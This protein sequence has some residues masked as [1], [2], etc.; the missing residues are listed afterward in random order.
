M[1]SHTGPLRKK[2]TIV[3]DGTCGK[4]CLLMTYVRGVFP[5]VYVPTVFENYISDLEVD[6][7]NVEL[8]LW[9]TAGQE[10]YD[11]LRPLSYPDTD[12]ILIAFSIEN[13]D[14]LANVEEKWVPEVKHFCPNTPILLVG[15]KKDLRNDA[16]VVNELRKYGMEPIST[17]RGKE[18]AN[19]IGACEYL[20]CSA[21]T[22]EG[23]IDVFQRAAQACLKVHKRKKACQLI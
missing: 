7:K 20:E 6:N 19:R 4:T 10:D 22:R 3:G 8:A 1:G 5:E 9:D 14:T 16:Q 23:I 21:K 12:V 2:L 17:Q 13:P 18:V 15:N 11:R